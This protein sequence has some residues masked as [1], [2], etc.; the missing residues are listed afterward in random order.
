[1]NK[2]VSSRLD[3]RVTSR[4][5]FTVAT[6]HCLACGQSPGEDGKE[7][8]KLKNSKSKVIG[9]CSGAL[10]ALAGSLFAGYTMLGY[11]MFVGV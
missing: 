2:I 7:S 9:R 10:F 4:R 6:A 11:S 3:F 5:H 1:M 8:A